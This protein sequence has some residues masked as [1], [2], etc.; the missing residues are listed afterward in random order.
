MQF[1]DEQNDLPLTRRDFL[2]EGLQSILEFPAV[3]RTC[4]H[5]AE[6][7]GHQLLVLQS[8]RHIATNNAPREALRDGGLADTGLTDQYRVILGATGQDLHDAPNLLITTDDR[9]D[10]AGPGSGSEV[11]TVFVER[12]KFVLGIRIR[13][14]LVAPHLDQSLEDIVA[15]EIARLKDLFQ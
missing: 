2:E 11:A 13:H 14:T 1:V 8:L 4:D 5:G 10:L 6:I 3:L 9:I 12:L 15:P 7:H